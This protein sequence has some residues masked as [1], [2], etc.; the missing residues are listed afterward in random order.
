MMTGN[1]AGDV[2]VPDKQP[3]AFVA[4]GGSILAQRYLQQVL[5]ESAFH[6]HCRIVAVGLVGFVECIGVA[7][8]VPF[9]GVSS[10]LYVLRRSGNDFVKILV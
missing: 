4:G 3:V 9:E 5:P 6:C 1:K 10:W 2:G 7:A 8:E